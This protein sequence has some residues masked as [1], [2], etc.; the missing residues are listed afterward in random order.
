M[1]V[2]TLFLTHCFPP[3]A[4]MLS[5]Q[6]ILRI[7]LR[8]HQRRRRCL[9]VCLVYTVVVCLMI[10]RSLSHGFSLLWLLFFLLLFWENGQRFLTLFDFLLCWYPISVIAVVA[11]SIVSTPISG[12]GIVACGVFASIS[13]S[14]V[15]VLS[16]RNAVGD[17]AIASAGAGSAIR[18]I[19]VPNSIAGG[20]SGKTSMFAIIP[21]VDTSPIVYAK[22]GKI[23]ILGCYCCCYNAAY[24]KFL[25]YFFNFL[26]NCWCEE[27]E[28]ECC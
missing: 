5:K 1:R 14:V 24:F 17:S 7:R 20:M 15:I 18:V 25:R 9:I 10:S 16:G 11:I 4:Q 28:S 13:A 26:L 21:T 23:A 3:Q 12:S 22:Y 6:V 2:C 19:I 27:E 8:K